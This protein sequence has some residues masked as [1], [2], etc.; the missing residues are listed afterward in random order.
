MK[1][2]IILL[3]L[4]LPFSVQAQ[5]IPMTLAGITL[6][7]D[8]STV[9]SKCDMTTDIVLPQARH[10]NEVNLL[11][12]FVPGVMRGTVAYA[13]CAQKGRIVRIKLRFDNPSRSF[14]QDLLRRYRNNFGKPEEW[15][16]DP[17]QRVI[18]WKWSFVDDSGTRVGLELTH[19]MDEDFKMGNSVKFTL[20]SLWDEEAACLR[21]ASETAGER[22]DQPTPREAL[23]YRQLIPR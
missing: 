16:G 10:L 8:I 19:S 5:E 18:S 1:Y 6:G 12:Q 23:D 14:F 20:R 11:S 7:E 3:C 9:S 22:N 13:N 21:G 4:L 17:F 2:I 15:R